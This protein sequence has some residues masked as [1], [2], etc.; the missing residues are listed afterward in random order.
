MADPGSG[1][2]VYGRMRWNAPLSD[3][4]AELLVERLGAAVGDTVLDLGSGWGE[5]LLRVVADVPEARGIAVDND[6]W[7]LFRGRDAA[8]LRGLSKRVTFVTGDIT[9]WAAPAERVLCVGASHAWGGT[10]DALRALSGR[11]RPGG[12]LLVGDGYW[13]RAPSDRATAI[14]GD[15]VLSL[16]DLVEAVAALGWRVI[17]LSTADLRE[18]DDFESTWRAGRQ[19]W[20]LDNPDDERAGKVRQKLDDQLREYVNCYRGVLGFAYVVL[21]R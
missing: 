20:L 19:E 17:H 16:S 2:V 9:T 13:E 21:S 3:D 10:V 7:A 12:R 6:V 1:E 18:W 8:M 4:H 5:L 14:F 15:G 11:V